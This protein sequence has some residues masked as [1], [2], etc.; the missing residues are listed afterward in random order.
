MVFYIC[1]VQHKNVQV[2]ARACTCTYM[3]AK[4]SV[5]MDFEGVG[6]IKLSVTMHCHILSFHMHALFDY[7]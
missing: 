2:H 4:D 1:N 3:H 5:A 6:L 7:V